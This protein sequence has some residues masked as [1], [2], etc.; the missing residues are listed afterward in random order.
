MLSVMTHHQAKASK[1][2]RSFKWLRPS[3][4]TSHDVHAL[5][6][7]KTADMRH[8]AAVG[9]HPGWKQAQS[10]CLGG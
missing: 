9:S 4:L 6:Q 3:H 2:Y 10:W 5:T 8:Y 1:R 7:T